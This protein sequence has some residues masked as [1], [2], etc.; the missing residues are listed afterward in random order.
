MTVSDMLSKTIG[1]LSEAA[2]SVSFDL[3]PND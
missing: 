2:P 3:I 1:L